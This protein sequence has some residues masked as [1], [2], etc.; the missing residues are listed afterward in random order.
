MQ[1]HR[2]IWLFHL[3]TWIGTREEK[4]IEL[5]VRHLPMKPRRDLFV[6]ELY[7]DKLLASAVKYAYR[8]GISS[9]A[10]GVKYN[11]SAYTQCASQPTTSR[12]EIFFL[13]IFENLDE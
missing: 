12:I 7:F 11:R 6:S 10:L 5:S 3:S 1:N 2:Q 13:V 4:Q 9:L 8:E